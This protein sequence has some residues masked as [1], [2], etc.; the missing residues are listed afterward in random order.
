MLA[1]VAVEAAFAQVLE[2]RIEQRV[3]AAIGSV[4]T[5][6]VFQ[7]FVRRSVN[8]LAGQEIRHADREADDVLPGRL[9]LLRLVGDQ[10]DRTGLGAAHALGEHR[11]WTS[12]GLLAEGQ[13]SSTRPA[14]RSASMV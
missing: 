9:E 11:H 8:V 2:E 6:V 10:H 3:G 7:R 14:L 1:L 12:S 13:N 5:A 4:L